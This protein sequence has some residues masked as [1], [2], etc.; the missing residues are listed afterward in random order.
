MIYRAN[1][2]SALISVRCT[3]KTC[4]EH[5]EIE[6]CGI[7]REALQ[8][9]CEA[10]N[11]EGPIRI[12]CIIACA[13]E[14]RNLVTAVEEHAH[15]VALIVPRGSGDTAPLQA[16]GAIVPDRASTTHLR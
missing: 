3:A 6:P 8:A 1:D 15:L 5:H 10:L 12:R 14:L 11:S 7:T 9:I 13:T 4:G 2:P 16:P